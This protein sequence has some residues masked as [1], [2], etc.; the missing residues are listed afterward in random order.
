MGQ[1]G[2]ASMKMKPRGA[3]LFLL[4]MLCSGV[5]PAAAAPS[6]QAFSLRVVT[7][8]LAGPWEIA[9]GPDAF[10][11][12]VE[13]I[14]RRLT[15]VN[16]RDG[17]KTVAVSIPEAFQSS[18][19]DGVLGMA[20][21]PALLTGTG[22]DYVYVAFVY[23]TDPDAGTIRRAKIRRYT[24]DPRAQALTDPMDLL[25]DLPA[26]NDH[27]SGRLVFGPDQKLYYSIGDQGSNQRTNKCNPIRSQDIPSADEITTRDLTKY[28]GKILRLNLDG[29]IPLDNPT[30]AGMR[31]HIYSYGHRNPQGLAFGPN[32][33]LY[34]S[35]HGPKTDDEINLIEAGKN[36]GW[37]HVAGYKDDQAYFYGNWSS[38]TALPCIDLEFNEYFL[39]SSIPRH[40]ESDWEHPD[41]VPP[42]KSLFVVQDDYVFQDPACKGNDYI[43]WPSLALSGIVVYT[44]GPHG[45]P[46]WATSVLAAS[47]KRGTLYRLTLGDDGSTI[48]GD[49]VPVIQ[50]ID[51][52]RDLAIDTDQQAVYIATDLRGPTAA[53]TGGWTTA[54]AHP[55]AILEFRY[56]APASIPQ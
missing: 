7:T 25:T 24:Y 45:I 9:W 51:R 1:G 42:L 2:V 21:H 54:L 5:G 39:P 38:S 40:K 43:C 44:A 47:L 28:Q 49:A 33:K 50:T 17:S 23:D 22:E 15:R 3:V 55:G 12:V 46:G 32:G 13:R 53:P 30:L 20:L 10:I 11:W 36:Y 27:N 16:P 26:S 29:S 19:Q 48:V 8:G 35:E 56:I 34:A 4:C 31:S 18:G 41:F 6:P 14:G 37:P 52:Y